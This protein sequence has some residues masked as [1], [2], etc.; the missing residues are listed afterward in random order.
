MEKFL[1]FSLWLLSETLFKKKKLNLIYRTKKTKL[2]TF[3]LEKRYGIKRQLTKNCQSHL[4]GKSPEGFHLGDWQ[5]MEKIRAISRVAPI[6]GSSG[7]RG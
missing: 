6:M 1:F 3:L 5:T 7:R 2:P 4:V